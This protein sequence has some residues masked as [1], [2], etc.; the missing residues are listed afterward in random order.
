V[1]SKS[2]NGA[3]GTSRGTEIEIRTSETDAT[4][5]AATLAHEIAHP[6]LHFKA[7]GKRIT[8]R[9]GKEIDKQ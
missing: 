6:L 8:T 4:T 7:D 3:V 2:L 5:Q 1:L 9:E